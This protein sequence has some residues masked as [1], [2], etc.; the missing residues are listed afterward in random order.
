MS[1]VICP[2]SMHAWL[3][4]LLPD[5]KW[6]PADPSVEQL[7][8]LGRSGK[9]GVLGEVG[10]DR[11]EMSVGCDLDLQINNAAIRTDLLQ[12]PIIHPANP[13]IS[14]SYSVSASHI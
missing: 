10:S 2:P 3:A 14:L 12:T 6:I 4:I 5:G 7:R 8:R 13:S 1:D 11:V 9:I